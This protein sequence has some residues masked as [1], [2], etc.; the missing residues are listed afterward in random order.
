MLRSR[1]AVIASLILLTS[2]SAFGAE[3]SWTGFYV[4]LNAGLGI[5]DSSMN[6][7]PVGAFLT[8]GFPA[9]N[10]LRTDSGDLRDTAFTGGAQAGYNWQIGRL[11]I[12]PEVD[13]NYNG[14]DQTDIS[15]RPLGN[16]AAGNFEHNVSQ[17][18][19]WFGTARARVG[20]TVFPQWLVYVTG[21]LAY[22][23]IDSKTRAL[24]SVGDDLYV[25]SRSTTNAGWT[26][27]GGSEWQVASR[28][29]MKLEYLYLDLGSLSYRD[30]CVN[31]AA[32]GFDPELMYNTKI[33]IREHVVR[34]GV[35]YRFGGP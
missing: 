26:I 3:P 35:N 14:I 27:G 25:G 31:C 30:P 23:H 6:L 22:G 4:G 9:T 19:D 29:S 12:G 32:L 13:F 33:R 17:K 5:N 16:P 8:D 20:L 28:W 2:G 15:N 24:F 21:G 11:V 18:F 10:L 1:A 7:D 34:F